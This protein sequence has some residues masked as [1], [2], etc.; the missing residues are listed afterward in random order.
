MG[1]QEFIERRPRTE[2]EQLPEFGPGQ[3]TGLV[4]FERQCFERAALEIETEPRRSTRS[5]EIRTVI[6]MPIMYPRGVFRSI[7]CRPGAR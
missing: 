5:S 1:R 6:S 7:T 4:F 2:A 3:M